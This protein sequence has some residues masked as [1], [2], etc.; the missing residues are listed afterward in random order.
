MA[1]SK[2]AKIIIPISAVVLVLIIAVIGVFFLRNFSTGNL[3][4]DI[5]T[6]EHKGG[7]GLTPAYE[8]SYQVEDSFTER[9][10]ELDALN[11]DEANTESKIRKSGSINLTV[12]SLEEANDEVLDILDNY[13]GTVVSSNE[14][15]VGNY[16]T[17]SITLKVPVEYFG[18]LF[19]SV[20]DIDG[21][22]DY[23]SYYTDDVTREYT[24]LE[25]RLNN[26][27]AAEAQLV[28]IL[29]TAETV[30]DTLAVY[31]QLTSTRSQIEVIKGQLKYLDSQVDY[32]YLTITLSLSDVGKEVKDEKWQPLGVVKNAF[33][34]LVDFGIKIVDSL[35]WIVV[36]SPLV[37]IPV[38]IIISIVKKKAK[39]EEKVV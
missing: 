39:K 38:F 34:A 35:I 6:Y 27:E 11:Y 4:S 32:S 9:S 29:E 20:K 1:L 18:D 2:R 23:A 3:Y 31:N 16:K 12:E 13:N 10:L 36:F 30:E 24:D 21:E 15:G 22:V 14:S 33:S 5:Q 25:S 8:E 28:K 37:L 19:Q 7:L 17:I 26:L